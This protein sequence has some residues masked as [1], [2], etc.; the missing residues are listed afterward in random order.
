MQVWRTLTVVVV[1]V[2]AAAAA[3]S[4]GLGFSADGGSSPSD[5]GV[6]SARAATFVIS[7][8]RLDGLRVTPATTF[9]ELSRHF[10]R[11]G[12]AINTFGSDCRTRFPAVGVSA[13]TWTVIGRATAESCRLFSYA[14]VADARWHTPRGL[15]VGARVEVMRRLYP[16]A[17]RAGVYT[18]RVWA[19]PLGST[20]WY[21]TRS[22]GRAAHT[23][24]VAYVKNGR[25][26][27][28]GFVVV[29]H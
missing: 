11:N 26:A 4:A 29:G 17:S 25:V 14:V 15:R 18:R 8:D 24:P 5:V 2:V 6:G 27:A 28:L 3:G 9:R 1:V 13:V 19:I 12:S 10:S 20:R 7:A 16:H 21:L 22:K 23:R